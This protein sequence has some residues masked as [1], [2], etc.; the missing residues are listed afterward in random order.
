VT[1]SGCYFVKSG[2]TVIRVNLNPD[3]S[4]AGR[5]ASPR[6]YKDG[7][8]SQMNGSDEARTWGGIRSLAPA[9]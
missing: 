5:T 7:A 8:G 9:Q 4:P 3:L 1:L 2:T 6:S